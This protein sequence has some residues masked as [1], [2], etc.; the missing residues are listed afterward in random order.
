MT[1][2]VLTLGPVEVGGAGGERM[3]RAAAESCE[4]IGATVDEMVCAYTPYP[5]HAVGIWYADFRATTD[6]DHRDCSEMPMK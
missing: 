2:L 3:F 1:A 6:D 4:A 5:F